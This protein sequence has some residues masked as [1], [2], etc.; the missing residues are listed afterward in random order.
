MEKE[1]D[2][3]K[4]P[5]VTNGYVDVSINGTVQWVKWAVELQERKDND[6]PNNI[7]SKHKLGFFFW[8]ANP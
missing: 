2:N 5:E 3:E 8:E 6:N 4:Y 1:T 7:P